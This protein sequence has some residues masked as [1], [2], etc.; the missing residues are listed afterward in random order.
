[1][2]SYLSPTLK[3]VR[4]QIESSI[5][6]PSDEVNGKKINLNFAC[7]TLLINLR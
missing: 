1:M 6:S 4:S 3:S 2:Q 5:N 7:D